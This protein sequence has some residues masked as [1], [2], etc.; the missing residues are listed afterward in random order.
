[1]NLLERR[2]IAI[3]AMRNIEHVVWGRSFRVVEPRIFERNI[4]QAFREYEPTMTQDGAS[5]KY[6]RYREDIHEM[7]T[8]AAERFI[9]DIVGYEN[10]N[11]FDRAM[12]EEPIEKLFN[13]EEHTHRSF[14]HS[15]N[16]A[17]KGQPLDQYDLDNPIE[18][19]PYEE[20]IQARE[21]VLNL[22][23]NKYKP[24]FKAYALERF[25]S[26]DETMRFIDDDDFYYE[27]LNAYDRHFDA[28]TSYGSDF[29]HSMDLYDVTSYEAGFN[30]YD[31]D[32]DVFE[33]DM[34]FHSESEVNDELDYL[35]DDDD[36]LSDEEVA[37]LERDPEFQAL[38][39]EQDA[40]IARLEAAEQEEQIR[41]GFMKR[42]PDGSVVDTLAPL[43]EEDDFEL[44]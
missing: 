18:E 36:L 15:F 9:G 1:M 2:K 6:P 30:L 27:R 35:F 4:R 24:E 17:F 41:Q 7:Y 26:E 11:E 21:G 20:I 44:G 39:R 38:A 23:L 32:D 33:D 14:I 10:I 16:N 12:I 34:A 22:R 42:L 28:V 37:E 8:L 19:R 5:V 31:V 13:E 3:D 40:E 43:E 29:S 25:R